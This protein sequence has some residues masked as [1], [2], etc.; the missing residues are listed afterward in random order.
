[1]LGLL[2]EQTLGPH[3]HLPSQGPRSRMRMRAAERSHQASAAT[4]PPAPPPQASAQALGGRAQVSSLGAGLR[5][6]RCRA[7]TAL[8]ME[9][10]AGEG[11][12]EGPPERRAGRRRGRWETGVDAE[13][14][15]GIG[16]T[17]RGGAG[18]LP[19]GSEPVAGSNLRRVGTRIP[20]TVSGAGGKRKGDHLLGT[21][22]RLCVPVRCVSPV[23]RPLYSKQ[24]KRRL[25]AA[26]RGT[27]GSQFNL[28]AGVLHYRL[29]TDGFR[30][31]GCPR[32]FRRPGRLAP[33]PLSFGYSLQN[34]L[35]KV[36]LRPLAPQGLLKPGSTTLLPDGLGSMETAQF[37][38]MVTK[39]FGDA[40]SALRARDRRDETQADLLGS[41]GAGFMHFSH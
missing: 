34:C 17:G 22:Y 3:A 12:P 21:W 31:L 25:T 37:S 14:S 35:A 7:L 39:A 24:E 32:P 26:G 23:S 5:W 19:E 13:G 11:P 41:Y 15:P 1:M 6:V 30:D 28:N 10:R 38:G 8:P 27:T 2:G 16:Q 20:D 29:L 40:R 4:P 36:L 18:G 33:E 9:P